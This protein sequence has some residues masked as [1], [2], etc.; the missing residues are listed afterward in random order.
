[1]KMKKLFV[2]LIVCA[3]VAVACGKKIMP[4][5]DASNPARSGNDKATNSG[6]QSSTTN[7]SA[8]SAPSFNN[9][10]SSIPNNDNARSVS[11]EKGK[12]VYVTKCNTCHTLKTPGDYTVD[13]LNTILKAEIPKAKLDSKEAEQ[14]TAYL[15][16]NAKK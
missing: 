10:Q 9:M 11:A 6:S 8:T 15:L 12:S 13:Q 5:S 16:A 14:V 3:A 1:M 7:N 4:E 2:L